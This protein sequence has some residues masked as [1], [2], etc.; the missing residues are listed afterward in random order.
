MAFI[1]ERPG[2]YDLLVDR[3]RVAYRSVG[4]PTGGP[5]DRTAWML[6]NALV[7]NSPETGLALE[8]TL[9]G[10]VLRAT[11]CHACAFVGAPFALRVAGHPMSLGTVWHVEPGQLIEI[12]SATSGLRGYLAVAGGFDHPRILGSRSALQP[13]R[14]GQELVCPS[15]RLAGRRWREP[16]P[17]PP[18]FRNRA[19]LFACYPGR[20]G[21]R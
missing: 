11:A 12:G 18:C 9:T 7:G 6:A 3:G 8:V 17:M 20:S 10:P 4:V 14:K 2:L 13:L 5:A 21:R 15:L 1:V 16:L 19:Y